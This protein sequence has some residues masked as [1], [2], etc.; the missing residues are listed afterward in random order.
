MSLLDDF[1]F[2]VSVVAKGLEG[3]AILIYGTNS[4]GKTLNATKAKKPVYLAAEAGINAIPGVP[5][6]RIQK[7]ADF[8]KRA[9]QLTMP[10]KLEEMKKEVS[11]IIVDTVEALSILCQDYICTKFEAETI[12]SGNKG[13]GLWKEYENEFWREI[14][15]LTSCGYTVIFISHETERKFKDE[16]GEE[17]TKI[18]PSGDKRS[19]DPVCDLVDI[20]GYAGVNGLDENGDEIPSSLFLKQTHQYHAR[21]RFPYMIPYLKEFTME[22]LEQAIIDA[23]E[24]QEQ[25]RQGSTVDYDT[26]KKTQEP[27]RLS[28][29]DLMEKIRIIAEEKIMG[30]NIPDEEKQNLANIFTDIVEKYL[31]LGKKVSEATN[32]QSEQLELI[33]FDL[34]QDET[35]SKL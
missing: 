12:A 28:Y 19:I 17:Y 9:R 30:A 16:N 6:A 11:T 20:I 29:E 31:G 23:I 25:E 34:Q 22:G 33:L 14:N 32:K 13:Y 5:F 15:L 10:N 27:E 1:G 4:T 18:Y 21:S 24:K 3:K 7:W 8:K 35:L 2:Q 26:F